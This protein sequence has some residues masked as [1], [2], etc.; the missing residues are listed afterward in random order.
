M[1]LHAATIFLSAFLLFLVQ[2]I[3]AKQ[4][5][6]W[7][8]GAA[9]VWTTVHGV[10]P[11]RAAA[12]LRLRALAH[13]PRA[14]AA[15]GVD[16]HRAARRRAS[17]SCRSRPTRRGSPAG[18]D[19]PVA[20]IL[21][22]LVRHHR[23]AL[24]PAVVH[25]PAGAGVVR[26]RLPGRE[27]VPAVR[28]VQLRLDAGAA[29]L[30]VPVRA[31]ASTN[32][33][34]VVP[35]GRRATRPSCSLCAALAW[36]RRALPA[37]RRTAGQVAAQAADEPRPAARGRIALWLAL[38]AMG[39]VVL[40]AVSNHLTQNI[41]S[42][43]LLW[44]IPLAIYLLTFILC[45]EGR[46][47]TGATP[48][49]GSLVWILCV[50][51]WFLADKSLQFEL[52]W[53]VAVFTVGPLLRLHVLPWRARAPA[54]RAAAPHAL[55]PRGV[56]GRR[57]R[58]RAGRHRR[59]G[60][61]AGLPRARD[62]A[63]GRRAPRA[64]DQPAARP[65]PIVAMLAAV[66]A[67]TVGAL[68]WRVHNFTEDTVHIERN[69]YGVLR[70]KETMSRMD[71]PETALPLAGARRDPARRA[72]A[73][74][75]STAAR[76]PPTT[77]PRS[78]IGRALLA[79]EGQ[80]IR[81]GVIGLGAGSLAVYADADDIYRFYDINPGGDRG[82]AR[83]VHLP[84]GLAGEDGDG[85]GRRAPVARA[86]GAAG[87]RRARGGRLLRRL[88]PDAPHHRR[89]VHRVPAPPEARG[90][91]RVPRLQPLPRPE[92]GAARHRR[93]ATASST[94]T[95]TRPARTAAPPATGWCSRAT[96]RSSCARRS[97]RRPSR[98]RRSPDWRLW[99][100]T[101]N[102]LWQVFSA[103]AEARAGR[104]PSARARG[105]PTRSA[106]SALTRSLDSSVTPAMCGV[107][108]RCGAP[109]SGEPAG[110]RLVVEDV[111]RGA[112]RGAPRA[113]SRRAPPRRRPR[114]ARC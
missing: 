93:A 37:A 57:A 72:V 70:V 73:A 13:Q 24:L 25:Q 75:R 90:R 7:F 76:R 45:F 4:I 18:G 62:R 38:S 5:L 109:T 96:S 101:Y 55:L 35:G 36:T 48:T 95:C 111:E 17:R 28:A 27:P 102:N 40:L 114:R 19:N 91:D 97:S 106:I 66:V 69:Y 92:A 30:P 1:P 86:R 88:D 58:R 8:G 77:R 34:A 71:E 78:G 15:A 107:S 89:G 61:A 68:V 43:P 47:G 16:P 84:Q 52:L 41:S 3:L 23:P 9:I 103:R 112:A 51:A 87:L 64:G 108:S 29:R 65:V 6:P 56:A 44:V 79:F 20:R 100:D 11:V 99:T 14:R 85:A 59:P 26:A 46:A 32:P 12:G 80:P 113:A 94:P 53:Q 54:P 49:S 33:R 39:S 98:S 60:D 50:M 31:V 22:L 63:G 104:E 110:K 74:R 67:F 42:I 10:L 21:L 82:G 83:V 105:A 81:V 2:P